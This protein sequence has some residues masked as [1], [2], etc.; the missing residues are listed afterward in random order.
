MKMSMRHYAAFT[1][2]VLGLL[3]MT[4]LPASTTDLV[5]HLPGGKPLARKSVQYRCDATGPKIGLPATPF[6]VEYINGSGNSLVVVPIYGGSLIFAN[7]AS[8][9]GA[10]YAAQQYVWWEARGA[11][12]LYLDSLSGTQSSACQP[13]GK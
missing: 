4:A 11:A 13:T 2:V 5:I 3:F 10:R 6:S 8:G 7:V 1:M 9:S 12:T